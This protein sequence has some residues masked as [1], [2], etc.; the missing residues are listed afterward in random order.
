MQFLQ[1]SSDVNE[2][3]TNRLQSAR[4]KLNTIEYET[5]PEVLQV[6]NDAWQWKGKMKKFFFRRIANGA[7][8]FYE[9]FRV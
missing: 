1:S 7:R 9:P 6:P 8:T 5:V 2:C 4:E 3:E